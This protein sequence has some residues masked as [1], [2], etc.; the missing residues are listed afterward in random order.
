MHRVGVHT[1]TVTTVVCFIL[2]LVFL[3]SFF[4][5]DAEAT[6]GGG[7]AD[8]TGGTVVV[9]AVGWD[10]MLPNPLGIKLA[11]FR[12]VLAVTCCS[13]STGENGP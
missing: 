6:T 10:G 4:N 9:A 11:T 5:G 12:K 2:D 1:A 3:A 13:D 7:D 8:L